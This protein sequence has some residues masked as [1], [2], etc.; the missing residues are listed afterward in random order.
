MEVATDGSPFYAQLRVDYLLALTH[1]VTL[2]PNS[3]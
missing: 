1:Y 3:A 2:W